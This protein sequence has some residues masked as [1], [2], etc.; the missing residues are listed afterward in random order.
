MREIRITANEENQ[1]LDKFLSKYLALAPRSFIY[2]MLR[3]KNIKLNGKKAMG[4]EIIKNDDTIIL[5][6]SDETIEAF[7]KKEY[8]NG[9]P[10]LRPAEIIYE[11]KDILVVNKRA[12]ELSQKAESRDISVNER[13][14]EYYRSKKGAGDTF[15]PSVCNR[16]DRNTTGLLLCGISLRGSQVLSKL[17]KDRSIDKYYTTIV[18][19]R[20][21]EKISVS[22]YLKKDEK[23]NKVSVIPEKK[24]GYDRIKTEYEPLAF[25]EEGFTY[26]K[27]KLITGKP[28]QIRAH[29][30]F[31]GHPIV[32]DTKYGDMWVNDS[33]RKKYGLKYQLLHAKEIQFPKVEDVDFSE[34]TIEVLEPEIFADILDDLGI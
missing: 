29:L 1:R 2:K 6:L 20:V 16:L 18:K 11:D 5:F 4:N 15:T 24:E 17:L 23:T 19:G 21:K 34:K 3:K 30:A 28:H 13:L 9:V 31:L 32:G 25:F 10:T 27:V 7:E 26:L 14:V 22:G 33:F 8:S 12:G